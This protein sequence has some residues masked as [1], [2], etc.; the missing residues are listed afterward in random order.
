MSRKKKTRSLSRVHG[1]KTGSISKLQRAEGTDR[2]TGKRVKNKVKSVFDKFLDE[3]PEAKKELIREQAI[4]AKAS[5]DAKNKAASELN[6]KIRTVREKQ[7]ARQAARAAAEKDEPT[8][9]LDLLEKKDL[10]DFY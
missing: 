7:E 6:A 9:L 2:Q 10:G 3:N 4:K 5:S 8:D 1:I